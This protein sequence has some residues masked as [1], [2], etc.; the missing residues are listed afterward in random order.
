MRD[1]DGIP[2]AGGNAAEQFLAVL[3]LKIFL[4]RHEDVRARIE[5]EQFGRELAEH[6][7]GNGE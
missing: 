6:V 7:I 5:H 2:V 1:D 4:A 3:G